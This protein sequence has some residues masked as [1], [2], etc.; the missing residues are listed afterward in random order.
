MN[1]GDVDIQRTLTQAVLVPFVLLGL[2]GF[3][4]VAQ[5]YELRSIF[6][7]VEHT[8]EV[9][10][11][12][13]R[14]EKLLVDRETGLRGYLLTG[15]RDFLEPFDRATAEVE[16][17][18]RA[19][20]QLVADNPAQVAR[21]EALEVEHTA[22]TRHAAEQLSRKQQGQ[23]ALM[24]VR[25]RY[26]KARMDAL[27]GRLAE[28]VQGEYALRVQRTDRASRAS[29]WTVVTTLVLTAVL[30]VVLGLSARRQLLG[31]S[32]EYQRMLKLSEETVR[33]RD[34][35]LSIATHE[36]K[37][38]LTS[39][40]LYL[41]GFRRT[42]GREGSHA[43]SMEVVQQKL[44]TFARQVQRLNSLIHGLISFTGVAAGKLVLRPERV[45]LA[46]V[47]RSVV[48]H[49][50][51]ELARAGSEVRLEVS[52]NAVGEW[53]RARL[54]EL[55]G[56]LLSNA[57]KYGAGKPIELSVTAREGLARL[58]VRDFG[59]GI[60]VA[61]QQ[62]IF[63]RFERAVSDRH[64]GGFGLGL[65]VAREL[66]TAFGGSVLVESTPDQGATFLVELPLR[67]ESRRP[68]V[69]LNQQGLRE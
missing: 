7:W 54:E 12:L 40:Q 32:R 68:E 16:P 48:A 11:Q 56:H 22:W 2:M 1:Q 45:D 19:L 50:A 52:E 61:D 20:R 53:D 44:D 23:E 51:G 67:Q 55:V 42:L 24:R 49:S 27:R 62:R 60:A 65:W 41:Q 69:P 38:P 35:F 36:L 29:W 58:K 66:V 57:M 3:I 64:Y 15:E 21:L 25:S 5:T 39:L 43:P 63:E 14:L 8:D 34:E 28:L 33:L 4:L 13:H 59:I 9:I 17:T 18:M 47:V 26:G 30:A 6:G 31:V 37:T 46:A 10:T